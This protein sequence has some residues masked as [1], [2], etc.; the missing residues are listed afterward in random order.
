VQAEVANTPPTRETGLMFRSGMDRD[1][2]MLF[3]FADSTPLQ[4]W[5][6]NTLIPLSISFMDA[7]G[8]IL[9][10]LEMPPQ[11]E[12]TFPSKGP[13]KYALEM[14]K[15]WYADHGVKAGDVVEGALKA[16]KAE[17]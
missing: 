1:H 4:F 12:E 17:E 9:N 7:Q 14:N 5:M 2:G 13:A 3:V 6:K 16:P 15:G 11:T 8:R 10:I